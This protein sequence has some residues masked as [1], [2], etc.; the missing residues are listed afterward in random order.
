MSHDVIMFTQRRLPWRYRPVA[1]PAV[2]AMRLARCS[3]HRIGQV[4]RLAWTGA[5]LA[6][7]AQAL[8]A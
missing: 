2:A 6:T 8:A 5:A 4:R 7:A 1:L 3:P